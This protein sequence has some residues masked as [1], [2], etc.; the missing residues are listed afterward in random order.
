[1]III[2]AKGRFAAFGAKL[3]G[4]VI[5]CPA[6]AA[7]DDLDPGEYE[8]D[9]WMDAL[10]TPIRFRAILSE[11]FDFDTVYEGTEIQMEEI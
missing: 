5:T 9:C 11:Y 8:A 2:E 4:S 7:V 6:F 3:T 10:D 1:M